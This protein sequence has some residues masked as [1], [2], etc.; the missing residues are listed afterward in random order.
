MKK[1]VFGIL[2]KLKDIWK[3]NHYKKNWNI[4]HLRGLLNKENL[5]IF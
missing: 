2:Q 1:N 5:K 3:N 4:V